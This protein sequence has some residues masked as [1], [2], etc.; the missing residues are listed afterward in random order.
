MAAFKVGQH[1][2]LIS[3]A[4]VFPA[5]RG[6]P[7]RVIGIN[8]LPGWEYEVESMDGADL[9]VARVGRCMRGGADADY[10]IPLTDPKADEFIEGLKKLA[11][12]SLV[13]RDPAF[14]GN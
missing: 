10:L 11:R 3:S 1:A 9:E 7:V 4:P 8:T 2:K 14:F 5:N 12:E 13:Q 6:R